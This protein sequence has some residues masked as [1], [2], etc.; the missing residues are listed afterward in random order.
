M[1]NMRIILVAVTMTGVMAG[2]IFAEGELPF[3]LINTVRVGYDSNIKRKSDG[4]SS[5]FVSDTIDLSLQTALSS[6]TDFIFRIRE[7]FKRDRDTEQ[8]G[9]LYALL[10]HTVSPRLTLKVSEQ[11]KNRDMSGETDSNDQNK[12]HQNDLSLTADYVLGAKTRLS[13]FGKSKIRR[14]EEGNS[15]IKSGLFTVGTNTVTGYYQGGD[16]QDL[17]TT[18]WTVGGS[19]RRELIPQRTHASLSAAYDILNHENT[20]RGWTSFNLKGEVAHTINTE[21]QGSVYAGANFANHQHPEINWGNNST[22]TAMMTNVYKR[23]DTTAIDPQF[24]AKLTY[25][26]SPRTRISAAFDHST[27]ESLDTGYGARENDA[28]TFSLQHDLTKKTML[29]GV[30]RFAKNTHDEKTHD[31]SS[32]EEK[33]DEQMD[34]KVILSHKLNRIHFLEARYQYTQKDREDSGGDWERHIVDIGWRMDIF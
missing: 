26:P 33:K 28:L 24:G 5:A 7:T 18:G 20:D 6:R 3:D 12:Y 34:L 10:N 19:I 14:F 31:G 2:H 23:A 30:L 15:V 13:F 22:N 8:Y 17:N 1:K 29:K 21:W 16:P 27:K 4:K 25:S 9:D 11:Y 32:A